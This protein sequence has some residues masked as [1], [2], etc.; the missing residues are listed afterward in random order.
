MIGQKTY[1][2]LPVCPLETETPYGAKRGEFPGFFK[3]VKGPWL[4]ENA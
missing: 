1:V 3:F 4:G 2:Y